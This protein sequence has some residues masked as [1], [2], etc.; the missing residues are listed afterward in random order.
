[1][2]YSRQR[3]LIFDIVRDTDVHPTA[4]WVYEQA[5]LVMPSIG[6]ATVYRNL[7]AL[8]QNGQLRRIVSPDGTVRFDAITEEHYHMQCRQCGQL[9]DLRITD[10]DAF[11]GLKQA[12]ASAFGMETGD[13][14]LAAT[15]FYG[16]CPYCTEKKEEE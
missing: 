12:A 1:M 13:V 8:A 2:K 5:R 15:L 9:F 4:E 3:N 6:V 10:Q 14:V 16:Q 7:N 11:D